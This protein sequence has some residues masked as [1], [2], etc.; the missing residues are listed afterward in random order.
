MS[1]ALKVSIAPIEVQVL[2]E[3]SPVMSGREHE[4]FRQDSIIDKIK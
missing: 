4:S 3:G 2:E 1:N